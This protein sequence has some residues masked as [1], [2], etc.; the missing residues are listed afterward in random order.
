[1]DTQ[2]RVGGTEHQNSYN[3][4]AD[5]GLSAQDMRHI[6]NFSY[7]YAL[8]FGPGKQFLGNTSGGLGRLVGGW[9][10]N[11]I[12]TLLA[13]LPF[14]PTAPGSRE[15]VGGFTAARPDCVG[16][17]RISNPTPNQWF[18]TST[19][20]FELPPFGVFGNCGR[21]FMIGPG[22]TNFDFS[23][24]KN[25]RLTE[26]ASAQF[27]VEFFNIFN[28]PNF[29]LPDGSITSPTFGEILSARSP[30]EIQFALKILF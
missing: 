23:A 8:P 1:M 18:N 15:N 19:S 3:L 25:T 21:N 29:G 17:W 16:S 22:T 11:G 27:R 30:R 13:G 9:Q 26:R 14:N 28:H 7:T 10:V 24:F 4:D 12:T 20:A 2:S 6:F 5:M